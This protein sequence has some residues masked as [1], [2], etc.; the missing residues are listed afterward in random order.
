MNNGNCGV[1]A[2][3]A[4]RETI[5]L[6]AKRPGFA[7]WVTG[8]DYGDGSVGISFKETERAP[9]PD[10]RPAKLEMGEAV[11]APVSY[12][13]VECGDAEE[14]SWRV[15]L[16]SRDCGRTFEETGRCSLTDGSFCNIGF[17]DG[18]IIGLDV[19]RI[20]EDRTAW[21][22]YI[23]I[24]ESSDGGSTWK[25]VARLLEGCSPYLWRVRRLRDGSVIVLASL[26][27]TVWGPG[28]ERATRNTMLPGETYLSKIQTF[29]LRTRDGYVYDGPH[30][31]LPGI[32][33][34][35]YDVAECPDGRLLFIA[36]DVQGTPV[37]RQFVEEK[38]G[39]YL[40]GTLYGIGRGAPPDPAADPQGG[41]VPESVVMLPDGLLI[42]SRRGKPYSCSGDFGENWFELEGVG[43]SLY[44]PFLMLLPDGTA[45]NFGHEGGDAALGHS[46]MWIGADYFRVQNRM[47]A[48]CT[49]QLA[50]GL[51]ADGN[52]YENVFRAEL[53][54]GGRPIAGQRVLFRFLPV[55]KEDGSVNT[56]RQDDAP[57]Q[58]SAVTD[59]SGAAFA[60]AADFDGIPDIHFYYNADVVFRPEEGSAFAGCDGPIMCVAALTPR[61]RCRYPYDAYFNEGMLYLSPDFLKKFP[62]AVRQLAPYCGPAGLLPEN[63]QR[64]LREGL[65]RCG[66]LR[67]E[68]DGL[69]WRHSVHAKC[70]LVEVKPMGGGDW[71]V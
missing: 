16:R 29:F 39:R 69:R 59:E 4:R 40:N 60:H 70:P 71:Y 63:L 67:R 14:R 44:Q 6:P 61:R 37:A 24:R 5:Y 9:D 35:E 27:G 22:D 26:Y 47:P 55:W 34:H 57:F 18:R 48:A 2:V 46:D 64:E 30:Y 32:G 7:A 49:L 42:G 21:C 50:R 15:Y 19:P 54:A 33:A 43:K 10:Y 66:V 28:R 3:G 31:V 17:P 11:G 41:F 51:S 53:H 62:E 12:A 58:I 68:T 13:S 38:D 20:N 45:A 23:A 52:R 25:P 56:A 8:F 1:R 65:C 36:G